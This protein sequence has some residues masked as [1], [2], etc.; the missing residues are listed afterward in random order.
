MSD[1]TSPEIA[2]TPAPVPARS[3]KRR[4]WI[5]LAV[6]LVNLGLLAFLVT[7]L[8]TPASHTQ[9]DPLIGKSAPGFSLALLDGSGQ[10]SLA[11]LRGKAVVL[12][13]W[14]S[15]CSPCKEETPMLEAS[16]PQAQSQGV[17]FVGLDFMEAS[18]EAR[19]FMQTYHITYPLALDSTGS[20]ASSYLISGLPD[21]V[22]ISRNG[23]VLAKVTGQITSKELI[24]NIKLI[25]KA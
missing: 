25:E 1:A 9:S 19:G 21:T 22:F 10:L 14:A 16:W 13:F 5:V 15:W 8:L 20:A 23:S 2:I 17:V 24:D 12:N 3:G 4:L 18:S 6:V 7:Q 11:S